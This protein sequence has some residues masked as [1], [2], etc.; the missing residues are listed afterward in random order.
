MW[1]P[2]PGVSP[3]A[4]IRRVAQVLLDTGLPGLAVVDEH[5]FVIG[6]VSRSDIIRA[7]ISDPPLD[8][9]G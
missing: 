8:L 1:S 2:V 7:V 3:E 4:G 6:F 9:W 5:G